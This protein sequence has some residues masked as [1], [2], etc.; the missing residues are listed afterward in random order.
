MAKFCGLP[1]WVA[2]WERH[3]SRGLDKNDDIQSFFEDCGQ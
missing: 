2:P 3:P 1:L